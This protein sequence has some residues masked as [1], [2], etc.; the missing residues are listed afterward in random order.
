MSAAVGAISAAKEVTFKSQ[1]NEEEQLKDNNKNNSSKTLIAGGEPDQL[2]NSDR[3]QQED[4]DNNTDSGDEDPED[5][6]DLSK[7]KSESQLHLGP[8]FSLMEQLEKDKVRQCA[9]V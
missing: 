9:C 2:E 4:V 7:L 1:T 6:D 3:V 5:E 8:Q